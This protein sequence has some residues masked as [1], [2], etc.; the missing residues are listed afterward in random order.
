MVAPLDF[1]R[2]A[3][4]PSFAVRGEILGHSIFLCD[5][6]RPPRAAASRTAHMHRACARPAEV[7]HV[8]IL[9][10]DGVEELDFVGPW[11]VFRASDA[12]LEEATR[13][14]S[15]CD[16]PN[17]A[18]GQPM[19]RY[20][21]CTIAASRDTPIVCAKGLKVLP[22]YCFSSHPPLIVV[23]VPGGRGS[24]DLDRDERTLEWIARVAR[25][26]R[27]VTSVCTGVFLLHA[28]GPARGRRLATHWA[29]EDR[30]EARGD[31]HIVRGERYVVDGNLVTSQ[32]VSAGID[33]SLWLVGQ[34]HSPEHARA[35]QKRIQYYPQPPYQDAV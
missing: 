33:M 11:E 22:D 19:V 29:S 30:L 34:L 12:I 13:S 23:V 17:A 31:A 3:F 7:Q 15:P 10:F 5:V 9:L 35:T 14:N 8:G 6:R 28:A 21:A 27:W 20:A 32:G 4:S 25:N 18:N 1:Q 16:D 24:R 2:C 26:A